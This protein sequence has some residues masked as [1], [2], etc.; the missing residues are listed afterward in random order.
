MKLVTFLNA[1]GHARAGWIA[2]DRWV[3]DMQAASGGTL[4]SSMLDFIALGQA[5]IREVERIQ[6]ESVTLTPSSAVYGLEQVSLLA[7]LPNPPSIRDFYAFEQH[8]KHARAR[9]GLA[10]VPEWYEIPAFYFTNHRAVHG[11]EQQIGRPARTRK[12]DYE[13]EI[14]CVIGRE[15]RNIQAAEA[16]EWIYGYCIMN[17]WSARDIQAEEVKIGLG[18]AKGKDFATS[19]GPY[20]VTKDELERYRTKDGSRYDLEMQAY[21]NGS[22]L[23][24]GNAKDMYYTFAQMIERASEEVMLYPGDILGSGTV[25]TGCILELGEETHRWLE[26]G[27]TVELCITGLGVLRN[28]I[29]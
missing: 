27:D 19:L 11:P 15:G 10:M 8:V 2:D 24:Y 4:P 5:G 20:L 3:V 14:A 25:G 18:P 1:Q 23:S 13:L 6:S 7:P 28:F 26:P 29:R 22:R 17:D 21:V 9:R 12:L 16:E